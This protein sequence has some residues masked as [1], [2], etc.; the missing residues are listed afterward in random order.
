[1]YKLI[2]IIFILY[3]SAWNSRI[4]EIFNFKQIYFSFTNE[5]LK[6]NS[7]HEP[8]NA[9]I[10]ALERWKNKLFL[11][12]PRL[13]LDVLVTLSYINITSKTLNIIY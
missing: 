2:L 1:M 4:K 6:N 12:T 3:E 9:M 8:V 13:K 5:T 10:T 11:I 7:K